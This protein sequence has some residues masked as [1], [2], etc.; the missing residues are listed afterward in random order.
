MQG[1]VQRKFSRVAVRRF[2]PST[3]QSL[4]SYPIRCRLLGLLPIEERHSHIHECS[5]S[6]LQ[7]YEFDIPSL[8]SAIPLYAPSRRLRDGPF[9]SISYRQTRYGSNDPFLRAQSAFNNFYHLFDFNVAVPRFRSRFR[10]LSS[11]QSMLSVPVILISSCQLVLST[12]LV[13]PLWRTILICWAY[14]KDTWSKKT[15]VWY[16]AHLFLIQLAGA[17][18]NNILKWIHTKEDSGFVY[19]GARMVLHL[20]VQNLV[21]CWF[22]VVIMTPIA[23][24]ALEWVRI[25]RFMFWSIAFRWFVAPPRDTRQQQ[26]QNKNLPRVWTA[27]LSSSSYY[28]YY[29]WRNS[30]RGHAG[31]F[32]TWVPRSRSRW[33][34]PCYG[35]RFIRD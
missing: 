27:M 17:S 7:L 11:L 4:P 32:R 28:Y 18:G 29:Y 16:I 20:S 3:H 23:G 1:S 9:L 25:G 5:I 24:N 13:K 19:Y 21:A 31:L 26:S 2:L 22:V 14:L 15:C 8:I 12:Y 35:G 30:Q 10:D 33:L 34:T 6:A